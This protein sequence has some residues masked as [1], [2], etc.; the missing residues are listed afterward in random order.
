MVHRSYAR[1]VVAYTKGT[2]NKIEQKGAQSWKE[3][4]S[5]LCRSTSV[6]LHFACFESPPPEEFQS[7]TVEETGLMHTRDC[8]H[9]FQ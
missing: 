4:K 7:P 9:R 6:G 2:V 8:V 1:A 5:A 3:G